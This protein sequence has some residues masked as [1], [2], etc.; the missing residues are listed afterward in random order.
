MTTATLDMASLSSEQLNELKSFEKG[1]LEKTDLE[2]VVLIA[3]KGE[4]SNK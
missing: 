3:V 2:G 1:F 4:F